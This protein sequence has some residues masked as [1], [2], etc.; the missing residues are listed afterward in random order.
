MEKTTSTFKNSLTYGVVLGIVLILYTLV[1]YFLNQLFNKSLG[2]VS[3]VII[4]AGIIWGTISYRNQVLGGTISYGKALGM[5]ILITLTGAVLYSI[6][7]YVLYK[8]IDPDLMTR[9]LEF[10][11]QGM[12]E[13]GRSEEEI[14][15]A[16]Q[17]SKKFMKPALISFMPIIW[18]GIVGTIMSLITSAFI[19]RE[20][21]NTV[22]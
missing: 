14:E 1:L 6:F 21:P 17:F 3:Y 8:F 16:M 9:L 12:I 19:K 20:E 11:E 22:A 10:T 2:A 15:M 5:G 18:F 4:L 13:Q 7:S